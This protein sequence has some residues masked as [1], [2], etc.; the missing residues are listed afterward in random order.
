VVGESVV[1]FV[2]L[3]LGLD[4]GA[5]TV[6]LL[7]APPATRV[8]LLLDG[9]QVAELSAPPWRTKIDLGNT[10]LPHRLEAVAY[11]AKGRRL[12]RIGQTINMPRPEAE[13]AIVLERDVAG[14]PR[15]ARLTW[16]SVQ[17]LEPSQVSMV[18]DGQELTLDDTHSAPLPELDLHHAHVLRGEVAF[19][20]RMAAVRELAFGGEYVDSS[21][22]E[23]TAVT[24]VLP[25][26][27][28]RFERGAVE[29]KLVA[30]GRPAQVVAIDE[31]PYTYAFVFAEQGWQL[32][33]QMIDGRVNAS[34]AAGFRPSG[35]DS[36]LVVDPVP[37]IVASASGEVA[38]VFPINVDSKCS[39][40]SILNAIER[41]GRREADRTRQDLAAAV[42]GAGLAS[43]GLRQRRAAIFVASEEE[44]VA[45]ASV[46][47]LVRAY[48]ATL[49]VP[50]H[51]WVPGKKPV[52]VEPSPWGE[53][54]WFSRPGHVFKAL[55][56]V[57]AKLERQRIVWIEGTHLP[58]EVTITGAPATF[59]LAR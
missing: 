32:W 16:E 31:T 19:G 52:E 59:R 23:L 7:V 28:G 4:A 25:E 18:L 26:K 49:G 20:S 10:L 3:F 57:R 22:T 6:E 43:Y 5:Q 2:T 30:G 13:L 58:Q 54:M 39:R 48:L 17:L 11:N 14:V 37:N 40:N 46:A 53:I 35:K 27:R 44:L 15:S 38:R 47:P 33:R 41:I 1:A 29:G 12:E 45:S 55:R 8:E 34:L 24:V 9:Q 50:L 51:V 21:Q 36:V 56:D 42:A